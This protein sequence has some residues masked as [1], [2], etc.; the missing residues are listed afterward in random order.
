MRES[1]VLTVS[2]AAREIARQIFSGAG[3][4]LLPPLMVSCHHC[5]DAA[6]A[7]AGG[8]WFERY[9]Q[10]SIRGRACLASAHLSDTAC[11]GCAISVR[12][13]HALARLSRQSSPDR[14]TRALNRLWIGTRGGGGGGGGG[15][16]N[17]A[18][19]SLQKPTRNFG[20]AVSPRSGTRVPPRSGSLVKLTE[21]LEVEARWP[22]LSPRGNCDALRQSA[23]EPSFPSTA[24]SIAA[25]SNGR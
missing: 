13:K 16:P 14:A 15:G 3:S 20:P 23:C 5:V 11:H 21:R 19:S 24:T 17:S 12:T 18:P 22:R 4:L 8:I 6:A 1:D 25:I 10:Q 2:P 7:A 9:R